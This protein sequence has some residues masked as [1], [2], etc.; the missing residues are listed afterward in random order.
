[1]K[2][3]PEQMYKDAGRSYAQCCV[4]GRMAINNETATA[5]ILGFSEGAKYVSAIFAAEI[6]MHSNASVMAT[7]LIDRI[8]KDKA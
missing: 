3:T 6:A 2:K 7:D 8:T 5:Y 1:M 4:E